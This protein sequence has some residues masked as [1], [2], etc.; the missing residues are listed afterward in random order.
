MNSLKSYHPP[1]Y[2]VF[3][4][5]FSLLTFPTHKHRL[6][7]SSLKYCK[8][9]HSPC[10][11]SYLWVQAADFLPDCV[12]PTCSQLFPHHSSQRDPLKICHATPKLRILQTSISSYSKKARVLK[13]VLQVPKTPLPLTT[14]PLTSSPTFFSFLTYFKSH[15]FPFLLKDSRYAEGL[16]M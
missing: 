10:S 15:V 13:I 4:Q 8:S 9:K 16:C 11:H 6:S 3:S 7:D 1:T 14:T 12:L 5:P 2:S